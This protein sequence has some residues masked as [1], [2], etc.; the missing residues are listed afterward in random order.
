MYMQFSN[1]M[2]ST[3][4]NH[5]C[6]SVLGCSYEPVP[7]CPQFMQLA[8]IPAPPVPHVQLSSVYISKQIVLPNY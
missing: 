2:A 3:V 7:S 8:Y 4:C 1:I 5:S 6:L